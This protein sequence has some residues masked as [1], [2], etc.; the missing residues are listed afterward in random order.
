MAG[1]EASWLWHRMFRQTSKSLC[2]KTKP[3]LITSHE[4]ALSP[5]RHSLHFC[6]GL[7]YGATF[8]VC[9]QRFKETWQLHAKNE[10]A[11]LGACSGIACVPPLWA[12]TAPLRRPR[13]LFVDGIEAEGKSAV[14]R[15]RRFFEEKRRGQIVSPAQRGVYRSGH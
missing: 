7:C 9:T 13:S 15:V 2:P 5:A 12:C 14:A 8:P 10:R 11:A 4:A 1:R 3:I 6:K